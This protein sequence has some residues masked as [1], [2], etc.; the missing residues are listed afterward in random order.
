MAGEG[1]RAQPVREP[2]SGVLREAVAAQ[3]KRVPRDKEDVCGHELAD[4]PRV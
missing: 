2:V 4:G 3:D 1:A